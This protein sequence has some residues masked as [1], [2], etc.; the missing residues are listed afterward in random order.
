MESHTKGHSEKVFQDKVVQELKKYKWEAP[1]FL[2][3]NT[4]RVTVEDLIVHWR[5]ELNRL[6][7]EQLENVPLTDN[8]FAQ[9]MQQVDQIANS[10][11][12]AKILAMEDSKGKIDGIYRD[13]RPGITRRQITLT[14]FKKAEVGG[15]DSSYKIAREVVSPGNGS[16]GENRFDL[17]LL[18][19]GLPLINI[20]Q[21]RGDKSLDFAFGQFRR[22]Y[23]DG[24]YRHNFLAFSQMMV[25][26]SDIETR[27]FATPKSAKEF[28]PSF[29]FHWADKDNRPVNDWKKIVQDFLMI[30]MAHQM[31][32]DYL[33]IDEA[34]KPENRRHMLMRPYQVYALRA[35]ELAA[36]G[37]DNVD[38]IKHGGFIWHTTGSGKTITSFKTA[39]F[40]S[41]RIGFDKVIF[42][43][44]RRELDSHTADSFKAYAAYEPV[45]V[46][47]TEHTYNLKTSIKNG[48]HGIIVTTTYKMA[49]L[50]K[51]LTD[52]QDI[53]LKNKKF[54]FIIDEAHRTTMGDMMHLIKAYFK[55]N[56]LF[57]GFTGTPLF[58]ENKANG[59][60]N[61]QSEL[62]NTTEKLFG[63]LLHQYTIN[64]AISDGNVLGF[65]VDY[66]NT[67]EFTSYQALK[68]QIIESYGVQHPEEHKE[69]IK[70]KFGSLNEGQIELAAK[71]M[72]ILNYNNPEH[73][74]RVV[75]RILDDW[76]HISGNKFFNA[77]L[78][79]GL[80]KR[81]ID[82]YREFK[83]QITERELNFNLAMTFSKGDEN[84]PTSID[85]DIYAEMFKDYEAYTG[86][87]FDVND[88]KMG[89][90]AYFQDLITR[91]AQGGSAQNPHNIDLVIVADQMLTGYDSKFLNAL[92]VD[93]N[94]ELQ[95]LI[96]AYSRT[97]RVYG[98]DK[99]F[100]SIINF[101]YPRISEERVHEALALY[102][103][104]GENLQAIVDDYDTA[105]VKFSD[106]V[107]RMQFAF[108]NPA[109]WK[110]YE[111]EEDHK[112]II[113]KVYRAAASQLN[114][115]KQYYAFEWDDETFGISLLEWQNYSG[116]YKNLFPTVDAGDYV[117]N[118]MQGEVKLEGTELITATTIINLIGQRAYTKGS[119]QSVDDETLRLLHEKI[120]QLEIQGEA[121]T[122]SLLLQFV[123]EE[124]AEG[125]IP[126]DKNVEQAFIE[127][128]ERKLMKK[129]KEYA[130]PRGL[131]IN[132][133]LDVFRRYNP[134][135]EIIPNFDDLLASVQLEDNSKLLMV[136][137]EITNSL[138][139]QLN[140]WKLE[141]LE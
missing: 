93:R 110:L 107:A 40:L 77:I 6:N 126:A 87:Y 83:R 43:V 51:E 132:V 59:R 35:I 16:K 57:Y 34:I 137:M 3:G 123:D 81:V 106:A 131:E 52:G 62:I 119:T 127:W 84:D 100:G 76:N 9:V 130:E 30:P 12:A 7:A 113:K 125:K 1:E 101:Q 17:I 89:I 105:V 71:Q 135:D 8:E 128:K 121:K 58:E 120:A 4:H 41:T 5:Q 23:E 117:I 122:A 36:L 37:K 13:S 103:S 70:K 124:L 61:E 140:D 86:V 79:V 31:V 136:K 94:L 46:D 108:P 29:V 2:D 15:G 20:E 18:I 97:N 54:V 134:N 112:E 99:E 111:Y 141:A 72:D 27:Y 114:K 26:M 85:K 64:E 47:G 133:L 44:D 116:A 32:G 56:S 95:G 24:E 49:N 118:P 69:G 60:I 19:N 11:D 63:P 80:K 33:I 73:I 138:R 67:G 50:V 115:V 42:M 39:L 104:G 139:K 82:Y 109:D 88:A 10:Y 96:Q 78:T 48:R 75:T 74:E 65:N 22:Y 45:E 98:K 91:A 68:S 92:Y 53:S 21:K 25:C 102:S 55:D 66:I 28:N 38:G 129:I 14:I 90:D